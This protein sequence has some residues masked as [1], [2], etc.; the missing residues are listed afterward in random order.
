MMIEVV[1]L[2]KPVVLVEALNN[3][4]EAALID[5]AAAGR[6]DHRRYRIGRR[7]EEHGPPGEERWRRADGTGRPRVRRASTEEQRRRWPPAR[8][9]RRRDRA[10]GFDRRGGRTAGNPRC[11]RQPRAEGRTGSQGP[12]GEAGLPGSVGRGAD[13]RAGKTFEYMFDTGLAEPVEERKCPL[14]IKGA[15]A[16][17]GLG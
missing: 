1:A 12:K 3:L 17:Q 13:R 16:D 8:K 4:D 7:E 2:P 15:A 11:D 10:D 6:P 14:Q 5:D 9:D